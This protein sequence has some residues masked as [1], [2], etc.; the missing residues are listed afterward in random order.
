MGVPILIPGLRELFDNHF[1]I[2]AETGRAL[3]IAADA[4]VIG[5]ALG[6]K[7]V[8][9]EIGDAVTADHPAGALFDCNGRPAFVTADG[10]RLVSKLHLDMLGAQHGWETI[11][12]KLKGA[13]PYLLLDQQFPDHRFSTYYELLLFLGE[14]TIDDLQCGT[15]THGHTVPVEQDG[16]HELTRLNCSYFRSII[17]GFGL[18]LTAHPALEIGCGSGFLSRSIKEAGATEI[19]G[20]DLRLSGFCFE[21][22]AEPGFTPGLANMFQWSY[23]ENHFSLIAIRNNSAFAFARNL[24]AAFATFLKTCMKSL[25]QDGG[26]YL[27]FLTDGSGGMSA[28]GFTNLQLSTLVTWLIEQGVYVLK[29]MRLGSMVGFWVSKNASLSD[30]IRRHTHNQRLRALQEYMGSDSGQHDQTLAMADFASE[31]ALNCYLRGVSTVALWG[32][33]IISYQTWRMLG[34]LY[35]DLAVRFVVRRDKLGSSVLEVLPSE[36]APHGAVNAIVDDCYYNAR[37]VGFVERWKQARFL[38][39]SPDALRLFE[40]DAEPSSHAYAFLSGDHDSTIAPEL[41]RVYFKGQLAAG[42]GDH[43][44]EFEAKM[45]YTFPVGFAGV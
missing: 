8:I 7:L 26:I 40:S 14:R 13:P 27:T 25:R 15:E 5:Y 45:R 22:W 41:A 34:I 29:M 35:P 24:D 4:P 10:P 38:A 16:N 2:S 19:I 17:D 6:C 31:I 33:G 44:A 11:Q 39:Q 12:K 37:R 23:P 21:T 20:T 9:E 18:P 32:R 3:H 1:Q 30:R 42:H 43:D 28:K 36:Q